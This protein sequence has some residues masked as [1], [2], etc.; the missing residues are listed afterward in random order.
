MSEW[1]PIESAPKGTNGINWMLLDLIKEEESFTWSGMY[2]KGKF[3]AAGVFH[4][5]GDV[6]YEFRQIEVNPTHWMPTPP[7]P[8][9]AP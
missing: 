1:L 8:E 6:P 9:L 2:C 4:K 3:Y 7:L 5:G